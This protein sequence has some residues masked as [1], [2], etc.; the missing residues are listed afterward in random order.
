MKKKAAS[1]SDNMKKIVETNKQGYQMVRRERFSP[2]GPQLHVSCKERERE[3]ERERY[4]T[5]DRQYTYNVTLRCVRVTIVAVEKE[6]Y[7]L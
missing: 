5:Q 1:L 2:S 6:S 7:I 3:R 4:A